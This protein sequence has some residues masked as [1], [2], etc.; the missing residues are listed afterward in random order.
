MEYPL[1]VNQHYGQADLAEKILTALQNIGKD[2][3]KLT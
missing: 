3:D 1:A 2:V